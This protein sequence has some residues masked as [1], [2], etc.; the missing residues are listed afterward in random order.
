MLELH[1]YL[2]RVY[3][4]DIVDC[5]MCHTIAIKVSKRVF[6]GSSLK[7][8]IILTHIHPQIDVMRVNFDC[9]LFRASVVLSVMARFINVVLLATFKEGKKTVTNHAFKTK[10]VPKLD[11]T[12]WLSY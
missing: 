7:V 8:N 5:M 2:K 4:D 3:E 11:N 12:G 6:F 9:L 1:P 10:I